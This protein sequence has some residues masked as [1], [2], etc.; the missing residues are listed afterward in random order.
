MR[1][2]VDVKEL[3]QSILQSIYNEMAELQVEIVRSG[4]S[5]G[6]FPELYHRTFTARCVAR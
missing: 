3:H 5:G 4:K 2:E 1:Q 6:G